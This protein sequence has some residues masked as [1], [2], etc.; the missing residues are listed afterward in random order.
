MALI[1][2]IIEPSRDLSRLT[3]RLTILAIACPESRSPSLSGAEVRCIGVG[4]GRIVARAW[5]MKVREHALA[6]FHIRRDPGEDLTDAI[7]E[8]HWNVIRGRLYRLDPGGEVYARG[9]TGAFRAVVSPGGLDGR[10]LLTSSTWIHRDGLNAA[11]ERW[12]AETETA[13]L[14]NTTPRPL[15][16]WM[17]SRATFV[18]AAARN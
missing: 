10:G 17:R 5:N 11:S 7:L 15:P 14:A 12:L 9:G 6:Q 1:T 13:I 4:T 16:I 18:P 2:L 8:A 3:A